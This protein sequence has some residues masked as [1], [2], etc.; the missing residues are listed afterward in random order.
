MKEKLQCWIEVSDGQWRYYLIAVTV[1]VTS[2]LLHGLTGAITI[3]SSTISL[4]IIVPGF[5][6]N[7]D[8][9]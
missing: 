8:R 9:E 5:K 4:I 1:K 2:C 6:G 3:G 7:Q